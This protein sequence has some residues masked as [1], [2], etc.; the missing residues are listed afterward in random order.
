[1]SRVDLPFW[2]LQFFHEQGWRPY[3]QRD[4]AQLGYSLGF[5]AKVG[6]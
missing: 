3:K 2:Y 1:M 4:V 5:L 6:R